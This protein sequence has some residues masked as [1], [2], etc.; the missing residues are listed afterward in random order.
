MTN[1]KHRISKEPLPLFFV[2]LEPQS[3]NED[4]FNLEFL[5]N[6]KIRV[7]PPRRKKILSYNVQD[8]KAI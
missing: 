1:V 2:H 7:E 6:C 3:N 5:Q 8:A 4:I